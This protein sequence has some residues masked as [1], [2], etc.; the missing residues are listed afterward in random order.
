MTSPRPRQFVSAGS[1]PPAGLWAARSLRLLRASE[2]SRKNVLEAAPRSRSAAALAGPGLRAT[3]EAGKVEAAEINRYAPA[4]A[5]LVARVGRRLRRVNLVRVEAQLVIDLALLVVAQNVVGLGDLLELLLGFLVTR[6]HVGVIL[7]RQLAE[8]LADLLRRG[9]LLDS[10]CG[11][12]IF[13]GRRGHF[14][15]GLWLVPVRTFRNRKCFR[16][17]NSG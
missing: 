16:P 11:V 17:A 9:G 1:G 7:T 13:V 2:N 4:S 12:I 5:A 8:G 14:S 3:V 10:E 15:L 6:I